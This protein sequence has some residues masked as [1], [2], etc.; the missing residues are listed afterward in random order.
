MYDLEFFRKTLKERGKIP[1][2]YTRDV[3]KIDLSIFEGFD[4]TFHKV[5]DVIFARLAGAKQEYCHC[6]NIVK[7]NLDSKEF[8]WRKYCSTKCAPRASGYTV[9]AEIKQKRRESMIEKYGVA[10]NS[11]RPE[12]KR[13]LSN[14]KRLQDDFL[15]EEY[16]HTEYVLK[17]RSASDIA[18]EHGI[19]YGTVLDRCREYDF[20]S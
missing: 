8:S 17:K 11:Q 10:Y 16:L 18:K 14:S 13:L 15:S 1:S 6:G 9:S 4:M 2:F 12:I 20:L 3:S 5:I 19:F 7:R